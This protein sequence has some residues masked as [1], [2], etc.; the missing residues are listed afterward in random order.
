M[1]KF[2]HVTNSLNIMLTIT[3]REFKA[4]QQHYLDQVDAGEELIVE[5]SQGRSYMVVPVTETDVMSETEYIMKPDEDL[6]R[7]ISIDELIQGVKMDIHEILPTESKMYWR[8]TC[9][10]LF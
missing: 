4:N 10:K 8:N 6:R 3:A 7:A 2:A 5:R 1:P 9:K